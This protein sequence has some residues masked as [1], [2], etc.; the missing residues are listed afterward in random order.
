MNI[1]VN[2]PTYRNH[3]SE[4][5]CSIERK[6][7][8]RRNAKLTSE[9]LDCMA[10]YN[11]ERLG[12]ELT[13]AVPCSYVDAFGRTYNTYTNI[14]LFDFGIV[15]K[16]SLLTGVKPKMNAYHKYH[17]W[18]LVDWA[19]RCRKIP[20]RRYVHTIDVHNPWCIHWRCGEPR[21]DIRETETHAYHRK[22]L[23]RVYLFEELRKERNINLYNRNRYNREGLERAKQNKREMIASYQHEIEKANAELETMESK[24]A[25]QYAN[26]DKRVNDAQNRM[27]AMLAGI[28]KEK[29]KE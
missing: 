23:A 4:L 24:F 28:Y 22:H 5:I 13:I 20:T 21:I 18:E 3:D 7:N 11:L 8:K 10:R 27:D 16:P 26:Y 1:T 29:C 9:E 2:Q 14:K 17:K 19:D 12:N 6:L 15:I 25:E